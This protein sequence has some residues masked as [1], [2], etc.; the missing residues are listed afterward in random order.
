MVWW[1]CY[2]HWG[3]FLYDDIYDVTSHYIIIT[4]HHFCLN[5]LWSIYWRHLKNQ[6]TPE[7]T[8]A[9]NAARGRWLLICGCFFVLIRFFLIRFF[10]IRFSNGGKRM[11]NHQIWMMVV[12]KILIIGTKPYQT[13]V[14]LSPASFFRCCFVGPVGVALLHGSSQSICRMVI[15]RSEISHRTTQTVDAV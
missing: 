10:L 12:P 9:T 1:G 6:W 7:L 3:A 4:C 8:I 13:H 5:L 2:P 11:M 15:Y 14:S